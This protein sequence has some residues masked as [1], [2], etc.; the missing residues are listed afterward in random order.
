MEINRIGNLRNSVSVILN[1]GYTYTMEKKDFGWL[2]QI[3]HIHGGLIDHMIFSNCTPKRAWKA[4]Y[5]TVRYDRHYG[6][7]Y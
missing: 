5:L 2:V 7:G 3:W 4:F 1:N 6:S